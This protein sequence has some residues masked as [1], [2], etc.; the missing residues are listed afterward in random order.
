[1]VDFWQAV[2]KLEGY[3]GK[4]EPVAA[5]GPFELIL[6][7]IVAYLADDAKRLAAFQELKRRVGT[8]PEEI[9]TAKQSDLVEIA[10]MGGIFPELRAGRMFESACMVRDRFGGDLN[11]VLKME[12]AAARKALAKFPMIG[13]PGAEKILLFCGVPQ[14][15]LAPESNGLRALARLGFVKE[16]K[17]YSA[18]YREARKAMAPVLG[19]EGARVMSAH[20]LLKT[21]GQQ[22]CKRSAPRCSGCPLKAMCPSAGG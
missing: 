13:E 11:T 20:S 15:H 6:Y 22:L 1:M 4:P 3:Y 10:A 7:E 9:L 12:P 5:R 17:N 2:G 19:N 16:N 8:R 18:M 21:H 14:L